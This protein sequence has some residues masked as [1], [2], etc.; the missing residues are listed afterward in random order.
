MY[1]T[2]KNK[3]VQI[4][5]NLRSFHVIERII[6]RLQDKLV[7]LVGVTVHTFLKILKK[8]GIIRKN[9]YVKLCENLAEGLK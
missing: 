8:C 9:L 5:I 2:L 6:N 3:R 4:D 1:D 7:E